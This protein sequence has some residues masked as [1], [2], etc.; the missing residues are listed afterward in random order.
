M[1]K[2]YCI[3][4]S[5]NNK[6]YVGYTS[7]SLSQRIGQHRR[8]AREGSKS[9]IH[10]AIRKYGWDK[11]NVSILYEGKD[12]LQKED[13]YIKK[14]GSYNMTPGGSANQKGRTWKWSNK[15]KKDFSK[16]RTGIIFSDEHKKN[17]SEAHK[18][19]DP[20]NKG[21]VLVDSKKYH[22]IY[23]REYRKGLKR[24]A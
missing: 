4:N 24:R 12:A 20:W 9:I 14:Y 22:T 15:S 13:N 10:Y 3:T 5:I 1:D 7:M 6:K 21:K 18:G 8:K 17:M 19:L 16:K 23:M 11:F 2:I